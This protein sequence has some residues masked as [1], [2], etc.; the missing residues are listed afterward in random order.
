MEE[1][2]KNYVGGSKGHLKAVVYLK[3]T[4]VLSLDA[5]FL[6]YSQPQYSYKLYCTV[7]AYLINIELY[8]CNSSHLTIC[9]FNKHGLAIALLLLVD[10]LLCISSGYN[11]FKY[12]AV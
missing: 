7:L 3:Y 1:N 9:C 2:R 6:T 5:L 10:Y 8:L 12:S 4:K 11:H